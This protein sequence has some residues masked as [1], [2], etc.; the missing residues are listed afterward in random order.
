MVNLDVTERSDSPYC[1]PM[2]VASKKNEG[3]RN[4]GDFRRVN[5]VTEIDDEPMFEQLEKFSKLSHSKVF[6]KLDLAKAFFRI[7]LHTDVTTFGTPEGLFR[8]KVLPSRL[9]ILRPSAIGR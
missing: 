7:L 3:I 1:I 6:P 5:G 9:T 4:C 2:V 8:Y